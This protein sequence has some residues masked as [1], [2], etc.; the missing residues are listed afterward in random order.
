MLVTEALNR[1]LAGDTYGGGVLLVPLIED[2]RRECY[3]LCVMLAATIT[4]GVEPQGSDD[5]YVLRVQDVLTGEPGS[6]D[7]L[8]PAAKFAAQFVTAWA[9]QDEAA[10]KALFDALAADV[11]TE[12]GVGRIVDGVLSLYGM[13]IAS[14]RALLEEQRTHPDRQGN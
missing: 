9:N 13:A 5:L 3:A 2:S 7:D 1:G 10:T 11:E 8:P 4:I 14:A 12:A 6:A